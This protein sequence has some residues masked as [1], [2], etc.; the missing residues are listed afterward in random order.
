MRYVV[1]EHDTRR[2]ILPQFPF[3][4]FYCV[5]TN[6]IVVVAIAHQKRK[7]G[8]WTKCVEIG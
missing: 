1:A 7:P 2:L 4:I 5:G 8:Y 6:E 3:N